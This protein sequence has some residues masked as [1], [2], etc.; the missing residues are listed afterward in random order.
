MYKKKHKRNYETNITA[1]QLRN[2]Y[3]NNVKFVVFFFISIYNFPW[4][5]L[6]T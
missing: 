4:G 6:F 5:F 3:L 1:I 2:V